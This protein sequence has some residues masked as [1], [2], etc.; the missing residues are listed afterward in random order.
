MFKSILVPVD[1][2]NYAES[3]VKHAIEIAAIFKAKITLLYVID[4]KIVEGP[5]LRDLTFLSETVTSFEYH[6]EVKNSLEEKGAAALEKAKKLCEEA[7]I[8]YDCKKLPGIVSNT[9]AEQGKVCDLVIMGKRGENASFGGVFL[10]SVVEA[11]SRMLNKPVLVV[12]EQFRPINK[13]LYAYDGSASANKGLQVLAEF[14]TERKLDISVVT[15]AEDDSEGKGILSEAVSYLNNYNITPTEI[16]KVSADPVGEI[17]N[18]A[19]E[20]GAD[21]IMMGAF[22]HST[23]QQM[24]LGSNT[25]LLI[26]AAKIPVFL[27]R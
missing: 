4:I 18:T 3:Q 2:S 24:L 22:G 14:T 21:I 13:I 15:V 7:K 23:F 20:I 25:T 5:L 9:V 12:D 27:Y 8:T 19:G 26:R 11:A 10:G 17:I 6:N 1:G 16:L